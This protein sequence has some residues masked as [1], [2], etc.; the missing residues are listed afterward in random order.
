MIEN[1]HIR[2]EEPSGPGAVTAIGLT[3]AEASVVSTDS[4]WQPSFLTGTPTLVH[5]LAKVDSLAVYFITV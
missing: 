4:A 2:F 1:V 3:L 5:K